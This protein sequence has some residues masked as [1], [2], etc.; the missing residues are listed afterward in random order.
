MA[1]PYRWME[2]PDAEETKAFVDAQNDITMPFLEKCSIRDKLHAR[3]VDTHEFYLST[4]RLRQGTSLTPALV[5]VSAPTTDF[6]A[7]T[8]TTPRPARLHQ[9]W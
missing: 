5:L 8:V 4:S 1:D 9:T 7:P 6:S 3:F 2:D